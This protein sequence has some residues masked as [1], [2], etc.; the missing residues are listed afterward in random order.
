MLSHCK[1]IFIPNADH[2]LYIVYVCSVEWLV[3]D[4]ADKLFED[5]PSDSSFRN[6]VCVSNY[7]NMF[8]YST[9]MKC[10]ILHC[11]CV[12]YCHRPVIQDGW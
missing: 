12:S 6:Q 2:S 8:L 5:G 11:T 4:E 9:T 1:N 10:V 3:L 7:Q